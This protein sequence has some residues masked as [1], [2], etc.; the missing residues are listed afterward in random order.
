MCKLDWLPYLLKKKE[1]K[2]KDRIT[3]GIGDLEQ[4]FRMIISIYINTI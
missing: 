4:M 3:Q 2:K 1:K